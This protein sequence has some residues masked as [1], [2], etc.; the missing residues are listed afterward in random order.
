MAAKKLSPVHPGEILMGEFLRPLGISQNKLGRDL[1]VP[2]QRISDIVRG[3]RSITVDT[4]LRLAKYFK[5]T[6]Q[7]WLNL[8]SHYDLE[9]A[10]ETHLVERISR[11]VREREINLA[12]AADRR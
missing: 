11:D 3:K 10:R 1:G 12:G 4:A 6:P 9:M 2:A 7:F 8:Q 5:T